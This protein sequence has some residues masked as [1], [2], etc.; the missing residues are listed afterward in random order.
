MKKLIR[1]RYEKLS[2]ADLALLAKLP[3]KYSSMLGTNE[4]QATIAKRTGLAIG[5][6]KSRTHRARA[7]LAALRAGAV[8]VSL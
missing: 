4:S 3:E 8:V 7:A 6:V 1:F 2:D 5:T